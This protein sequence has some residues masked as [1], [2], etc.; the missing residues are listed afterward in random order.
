MFSAIIRFHLGRRHIM[1]TELVCYNCN[2]SLASL[3]LPLS[4]RDMC[5]SCA[6]HLHVCRMCVAYDP[7]VIGQCREDDAEDVLDKERLNFCEWFEPASGAFDASRQ[8]AQAE[9]RAELEGLFGGEA[10]DT[11]PSDAESLA[12][13]AENL[14]K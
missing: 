9:A 10:S 1:S 4:R 8:D 6:V 14:F 7:T 5:P 12:A 2:Y 13:D 3:S 11:R